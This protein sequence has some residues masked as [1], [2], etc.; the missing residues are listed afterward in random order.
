MANVLY[1]NTKRTGYSPD[2]CKNTMTVRELINY[3]EDCDEDAPVYFKNDD[4]YTY[5]S[6]TYSDIEEGVLK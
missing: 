6:I 1:L 4:G 5:G 2:Q 3:L